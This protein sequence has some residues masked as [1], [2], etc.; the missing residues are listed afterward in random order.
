MFKIGVME[1]V[2]WLK[3]LIFWQV[4]DLRPVPKSNSFTDIIKDFVKVSWAPE[5]LEIVFS[6]G[7]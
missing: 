4:A 5:H 6:D 7:K 3:K 2:L 1:K